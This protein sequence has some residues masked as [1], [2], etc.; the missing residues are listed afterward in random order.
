VLLLK[1]V[2]LFSRWI[3]YDGV[4]VLN[5]STVALGAFVNVRV[6]E[7]VLGN[8]EF[9]LDGDVMAMAVV[10]LQCI[11]DPNYYYFFFVHIIVHRWYEDQ[12]ASP[13]SGQQVLS[14]R[15]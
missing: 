15:I 5:S 12:V 3:F 2:S 9:R 10:L 13:Y 1:S 14:Q 4:I 6:A 8:Q 7:Y 11:T